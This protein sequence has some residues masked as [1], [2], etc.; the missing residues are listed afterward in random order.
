MPCHA[1]PCY[2]MPCFA[3]P[4]HALLRYAMPCFATLCYA[5]LCYAMP[6]YAMPCYAMPCHAMLCH[7]MPCHALLRYCMPCYAMLHLHLVCSTSLA[8]LCAQIWT[9][10]IAHVCVPL[11]MLVQ[12]TSG[13]DPSSR[14]QVWS[15]L[16]KYKAGRVIVL[17]THFMDEVCGCHTALTV[18]HE[19]GGRGGGGNRCVL[20]EG[21]GVCVC[22]NCSFLASMWTLHDCFGFPVGGSAG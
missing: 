15:L 22:A 12:P 13:L 7:A 3:M 16:E 6:C 9:H 10:V 1:M 19:G 14:R 4:C 17:T 2:A 20:W 11:R 18:G 21:E 5:M 8:V